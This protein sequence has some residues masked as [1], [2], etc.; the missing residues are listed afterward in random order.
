MHMLYDTIE[1][2][3]RTATDL[4]CHDAIA[5]QVIAKACQDSGHPD[6]PGTKYRASSIGRPWILQT[7]DRWY[8]RK[9]KITVANATTMLSG[10]LAQAL[11][12]EILRMSGV[13]FEE[14]VA[15][16]FCGVTGHVD[17]IIVK[18]D[19]VLV[20]E[21]KSMASYVGTSFK[22]NPTDKY[23]YVS[24]LSFYWECVRRLHPDKKVSAAF[25][26]F[27]RDSCTF[28]CIPLA[29]HAMKERIERVKTA[30]EA[31]ASVRDY[32]VDKLLSTVDIPPCIGGK[33]PDSVTTSRWANVLYAND[34]D[35]WHNQDLEIVARQLKDI[36]QQRMDYTPLH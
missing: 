31:L 35:G 4:E 30:T 32:D 21:C 36:P 9:R 20:L 23:G 2:L 28:S 11:L 8:G 29:V 16:H 14:E 27:N 7:L 17:F 19:E 22:A 6:I 15:V 18:R 26:L 5:Q 12:S 13:K 34:G 10:R 24:Q 3:L 1:N 33:L 25:V